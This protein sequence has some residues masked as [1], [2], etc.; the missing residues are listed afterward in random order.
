MDLSETEN[1]FPGGGE[2]EEVDAIV[3]TCVL[4]GFSEVDETK[5][6]IGSLPENHE[7]KQGELAIQNFKGAA[8]ESKAFK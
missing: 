4:G 8:N 3:K 2:E 6:L 1:N 5:T 7:D